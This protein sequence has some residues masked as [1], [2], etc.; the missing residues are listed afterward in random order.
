MEKKSVK[1]SSI[2][3]ITTL[4]QLP[5]NY[6]VQYLTIKHETPL[7]LTIKPLSEKFHIS[8]T[9]TSAPSPIKKRY[10]ES[11]SEISSDN[12]KKHIILSPFK[13]RHHEECDKIDTVSAVKQEKNETTPKKQSTPSTNHK[14]KKNHPSAVQETKEKKVK[15]IR[16]LKF[17]E[18][19]SSPVSGTIIRTLDEIDENDIRG[20][21]D[22]DPQYNIVEVTEEAKFELQQIKNVI[23]AYL[24]KLCQIEFDDAFGLA[25]HRCNCIV[26][27]EYRCPECNKR[28]NCPANLGNLITSINFFFISENY[29]NIMYNHTASH[30]RWHKPRNEVNKKSDS[31]DHDQ[32]IP[33]KVCGKNFKRQAYLNKHM[34]TH[35]NKKST[36]KGLLVAC[37]DSSANS[38]ILHSSNSHDNTDDVLIPQTVFKFNCA[39]SPTPSNSSSRH[40]L[41]INENSNSTVSSMTSTVSAK[42]KIMNSQFTED[43]NIAISALTNLRNGASVIRHTL[44][45]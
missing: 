11:S 1:S 35:N 10:R 42:F 31:Q 21:G 27:L 19:R 41:I 3:L 14:I 22:I 4:Q 18:F 15:A 8:M 39:A 30:R 29:I 2:G 13:K 40:E 23:G 28:F 44:A 20:S 12:D 43:E 37:N 16:K 34:A 38:F 32:S 25:R 45:V 36:K 5:A 26:L 17:D 33:C 7:D 6:K 24:C 9:T